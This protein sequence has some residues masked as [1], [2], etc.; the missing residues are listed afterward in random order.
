M[1]PAHARCLAAVYLS[2]W[3]RKIGIFHLFE[4]MSKF[5]L[6]EKA[7]AIDDAI[8]DSFFIASKD[9]LAFYQKGF[10]NEGFTD[11]RLRKWVP[12]KNQI[13]GGLGASLRTRHPNT[14]P[15]LTKS[16]RL[17]K[18]LKVNTNF[19]SRITIWTDVEYAAVHN[20]GLRSG[21]GFKMPKRKFLGYS[22]TLN[23]RI[24]AKMTAKIATAIKNA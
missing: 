17:R 14:L 3:Q 9:A 12:R 20:E 8:K 22:S 10:A 16:G 24:L 19:K 23:R 2:V 18:S 11:E 1:R 4:L 7:K 21:R 15:T 5:K 6:K 13:R